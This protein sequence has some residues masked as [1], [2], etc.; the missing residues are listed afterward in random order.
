MHCALLAQVG[1]IDDSSNEVTVI[2]YTFVFSSENEIE[3]DVHGDRKLST[4]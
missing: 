3:L 1:F 4:S 2:R